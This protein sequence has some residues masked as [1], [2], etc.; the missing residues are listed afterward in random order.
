MKTTN[1]NAFSLL[2]LSD[3]EIINMMKS[4][5]AEGI[6]INDILGDKH[7]EYTM[8][9]ACC[10]F[11]KD[12][13]LAWML[14]QGADIDMRCS[15]TTALGMLVS[16][17]FSNKERGTSYW[18]KFRSCLAI[19]KKHNANF[20]LLNHEKKKPLF[21]LLEYEKTKI[22]Q[23]IMNMFFDKT[24]LKE[25]KGPNIIDALL[26][27]EVNFTPI[28]INYIVEKKDYDLNGKNEPQSAIAFSLANLPEKIFKKIKKVIEN[29]YEKYGFKLNISN[30]VKKDKSNL[31]LPIELAITKKN[32]SL[33]KFILEKCPEIIKHKF[34]SMDLTQYCA[35]V[36]F[37][38]GLKYMLASNQFNWENKEDL[39]NICSRNNDKAL[40][41][42]E[43]MKHMYD[44]LS[45]ELTSNVQAKPVKKMKL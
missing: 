35:M 22:P 41:K 9:H 16:N 30:N 17:F 15:S 28:N 31:V 33:F 24:T 39:V 21:T 4:L 27:N 36:G 43:H 34:G 44:S 12:K 6:S 7:H 26:K 42:K 45:K 11:L 19:L 14:E 8:M 3:Q 5:I 18:S 32:L 38:D 40:V 2:E 20:D 1:I 13:A 37:K 25:K 29:I 23:E 10:F